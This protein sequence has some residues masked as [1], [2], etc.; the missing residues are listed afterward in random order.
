[1]EDRFQ[2]DL[3]QLWNTEI[4]AA[5]ENS[6]TL[7]MALFSLDG[8][9]L[10]ANDAMKLFFQ[11]SP[12]ESFINPRFESIA[13]IVTDD[14]PV[15]SGFITFGSMHSSKNI[16]IQAKMFRRDK[17]LLL[18][19][20]VDVKQLLL[21]NDRLFELNSEVN[22]LQRKL[23]KEKSELAETLKELRESQS[24]IEQSE[25]KIKG[26]LSEKELLL[27]EVHHR[28]KNNM[29]TIKGLL[30]IQ[31]NSMEDSKAADAL[32][33]AQ[34]RVQSMMILYDKLYQSPAFRELPVNDYLPSLIKEIVENF[35]N[36][37][38]VKVETEFDN[39]VLDMSI[40]QPLGIII[41]ELL[42]NIMKYAFSGRDD[43]LIKVSASLNN[44]KVSVVIADNGIGLPEAIN[45]KNST[46]FGMKLVSLLTEQI[47]GTLKIERGDGTRFVIEFDV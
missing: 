44:N 30:F 45:F 3:W 39:F 1:M 42:T 43:G 31:A 14:N 6:N 12:K 5:C 46:G 2:A 40:I 26:M 32:K 4:K 18:T 8:D 7:C 25:L 11:D 23:F 17:Q 38:A 19:G 36:C 16:S 35:N 41:N 47:K 20:E 10:F 29:N 13:D 37:G 24:A 33:D 15:F 9:L 34:G 22:D 28:I 21:L 27:K